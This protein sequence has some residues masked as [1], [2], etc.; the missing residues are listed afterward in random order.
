VLEVKALS[1]HVPIRGRKDAGLSPGALRKK[2]GVDEKGR[3]HRP[4]PGGGW[5]RAVS[6]GG[7][8]RAEARANVKKAQAFGHVMRDAHGRRRLQ[9]GDR[10]MWQGPTALEGGTAVLAATAGAEAA[11]EEVVHLCAMAAG[12][13]SAVDELDL[14]LRSAR[15][16]SRAAIALHVVVSSHTHAAV[17]A[18]L[19]RSRAAW[20]S[21]DVTVIAADK[22]QAMV[23]QAMPGYNASSHHTGAWG[24]AKTFLHRLLPSVDRCILIDTDMLLLAD[25]AQLWRRFDAFG[26]KTLM[27]L[28]L[29]HVH[30]PPPSAAVVRAQV[31]EAE[32]NG[33]TL[34]AKV[35][36]TIQDTDMCTCVNLLHLGRMRAGAW[37][38]MVRDGWNAVDERKRGDHSKMRVSNQGVVHL[39][40]K[41]RPEAFKHLSLGWN[42]NH[43]ANFYG[44]RFD[45]AAWECGEAQ[46]AAP[47]AQQPTSE[48]LFAG[49][50]HANCGKVKLPPGIKRHSKVPYSESQAEDAFFTSN[51][52]KRPSWNDFSKFVAVVAATAW[53][54]GRVGG[55]QPGTG[56]ATGKQCVLRSSAVC[57]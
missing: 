1:Q 41:Q 39:A 29:L 36:R 14:M 43:C 38:A 28:P 42:L 56:E 23:A 30:T 35:A 15:A 31:R 2:Y 3:A 52:N 24:A 48:G 6:A 37:E 50:F 25:V 19:H 5:E 20:Q 16:T 7:R 44:C 47:A 18:L 4:L 8:A 55:L 12:K 51:P 33:G 26:P 54:P 40:L 45:S 11:K 13:V 9:D 17:R 49:A 27:Q 53:A 34:G 57:G 21:S 10:V 22:V 32:S 46:G